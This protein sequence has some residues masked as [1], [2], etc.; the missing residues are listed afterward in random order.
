LAIEE[1]EKHGVPVTQ[2][3]TTAWHAVLLFK[4]PH[5]NGSLAI[6]DP[7]K[8]LHKYPLIFAK[9][10]GASNYSFWHILITFLS[11]LTFKIES[12]MFLLLPN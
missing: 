9:D 2:I 12:I 3:K 1:A 6:W 11:I 10:Q 4:V 8:R 7:V 5:S